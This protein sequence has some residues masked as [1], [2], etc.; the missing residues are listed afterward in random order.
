M[1]SFDNILK[2]IYHLK[3]ET[4]QWTES[5]HKLG[6]FAD[7]YN[8]A[9]KDSRKL[10]DQQTG[11]KVDIPD[12]A[13]KGGT[14]TNGNVCERLLKDHRDV[15][16]SLVPE[17]FQPALNEFLNRLWVILF[18]YTSQS[19]TH[20]NTPLFREFCAITYELLLNSFQNSE[21]KWLNI[22]PTLHMLL[23]HSW[24]L[25]EIN[26][27]CGLGEFSETGLEHNNKFLRFF[28]QF[29]ARKKITRVKSY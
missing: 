9:K 22:S 12:A 17:R 15:L 6:K 13:G 4:F 20:V 23:A 16:V 19:K 25:I 8:T 3:S 24:E 7:I 18:V 14:T 11:I 21:S 10:I 26:D 27:N 2:L 28:R 29:R 1:R 5:S